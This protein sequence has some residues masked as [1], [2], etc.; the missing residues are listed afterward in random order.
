MDSEAKPACFSQFVAPTARSWTGP[1]AGGVR[2]GVR[3]RSTRARLQ[4]GRPAQAKAA[5]IG[6]QPLQA[7]GNKEDGKEGSERA[8]Y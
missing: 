1:E 7:E 2:E 6:G 8:R 5:W 3:N 4:T